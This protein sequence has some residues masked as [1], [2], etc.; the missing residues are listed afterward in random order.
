M[1]LLMLLGGALLQLLLGVVKE[2][3]RRFCSLVR[4][5]ARAH[6]GR[7]SPLCFGGLHGVRLSLPQGPR[8]L[9]EIGREARISSGSV[10]ARR[11]KT[12]RGRERQ[13]R[14]FLVCYTYHMMP[15]HR[16]TPSPSQ[17]IRMKH[18]DRVFPSLNS[19]FSIFVRDNL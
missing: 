1:G 16:S 13:S 3:P 19:T 8:R 18:A 6:G 11:S 10:H 12:R 15:P 7:R 4:D 17:P 9:K 5:P 14:F 2:V